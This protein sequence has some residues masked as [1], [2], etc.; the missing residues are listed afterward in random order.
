MFPNSSIKREYL[1]ENTGT[2]P[3][4]NRA[5]PK[6]V[7]QDPG[8]GERGMETPGNQREEQTTRWAGLGN[9]LEIHWKMNLCACLTVSAAVGP[10]LKGSVTTLIH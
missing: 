5:G 1:I 4:E 7:S 6:R 2:C 3:T 10:P 9:G 8:P